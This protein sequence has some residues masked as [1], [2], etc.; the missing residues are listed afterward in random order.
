MDDGC[1]FGVL[2]IYI[3][4]PSKIW[5]VR[6]ASSSSAVR[7]P[8]HIV[9]PDCVTT[10]NSIL[11]LSKRLISSCTRKSFSTGR[12]SSVA[13]IEVPQVPTLYKNDGCRGIAQVLKLNNT[14]RSPSSAQ[15]ALNVGI[16]LLDNPRSSCDDGAMGRETIDQLQVSET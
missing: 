16:A 14:A 4:D 15:Q 12:F 6:R 5:N 9:H 3:R 8:N 13:Y 1:M 10:T 7:N 11:K 2:K